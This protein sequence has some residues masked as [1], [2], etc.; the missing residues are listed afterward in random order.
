[1]E[2]FD[3]IVVGAGPA[4]STTA[5]R[6][7]DA[8]ARVL[9]VDRARFPR[10]KP[11]G[12]GLTLRAVRNMPVDPAPVVEECVDTMELRL[13][14]GRSFVRTA[15]SPLILMTQRVRLDHFL[16]EQAAERG[17]MVRDGARVSELEVRDDGVRLSVDRARV[18]GSVL[19]GADGANGVTARALGMEQAFD[20]G[21][22]YEGNIAGG[23]TRF[24]GRAVIELG[25]VAGGYGWVFPKG[26]HVNVGVGGWLREGPKLK[27]RLRAVARAHGLDGLSE[28]RGHRLPMR[29]P[30]S[31][32]GRGRALLVGDAAGLVDPL[33]G[34]GMYECF[35]SSRLASAAIL[36]LLGGEAGT[37]EPYGTALTRELAHHLAASWSVRV[38][39]ER[40]PRTVFA[41]LRVPGVFGAVERILRGEL[42]HPGAARGLVRA[43]MRALALLGRAAGSPGETYKSEALV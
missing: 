18:E 5:Y 6:L 37:L 13:S 4:G 15:A 35:V 28:L 3:A 27:E 31:P 41:L 42:S 12:G 22:A 2:R 30:S 21:V 7:A 26:D 25:V 16:L 20:W 1:V 29:K 39:L 9:V 14:F 17:A 36:D 38:A 32:L 19:V 8:G 43:P 40:Y 34:D 23:K 11:C 24:R 33:S 10:D